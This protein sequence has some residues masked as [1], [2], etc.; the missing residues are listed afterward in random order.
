MNQLRRSGIFF[1][2]DSFFMSFLLGGEYAL[3]ARMAFER[4]CIAGSPV[5]AL[6]LLL[7]LITFLIGLAAHKTELLVTVFAWSF[8]LSH[9]HE[10]Y[11]K[12]NSIYYY[13]SSA[14]IA[15]MVCVGLILLWCVVALPLKFFIHLDFNP[16]KAGKIA[17]A[18]VFFVAA[19]VFDEYF[20]LRCDCAYKPFLYQKY[21]EF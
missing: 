15:F 13:Q 6:H 9:G 7:L 4:Q 2:T 8:C 12:L 20:P 19:M 18:V 1:A 3:H 21:W 11:R 5:I 14:E 10:S 17:A 16:A